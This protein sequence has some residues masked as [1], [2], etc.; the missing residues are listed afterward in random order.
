MTS[1]QLSNV[2][3][4]VVLGGLILFGCTKNS[5]NQPTATTVIPAEAAEIVAT[6]ALPAEQ[7]TAIAEEVVSESVIDT[8]QILVSD[9]ID[10]LE[11]YYLV[12][13]HPEA[14]VAVHLW[15]TLTRLN[16]QLEVEP[17]LAES[18]RLVN[19]FTWEFKLRPNLFFHNDEQ[20]TA[21]AVKF[22]ATRSK[23]LPS[24]LE[25]FMEDADIKTVE[26]VDEITVRF[27]TNQPITNLPYHLTFLEI[28]P[29]AYYQ[30]TSVSQL[31]IAPVGSGPYRL[32]QETTREQLVLE[33]A[34]DYWGGQPVISRLIFKTMPEAEDRLAE[35][36]DD[37]V[38]TIVTDLPP[39]PLAEWDISGSRLE[40]IESTQRLFVGMNIGAN[41][42]F[43]NQLVRQAL[44]YAVDVEQITT[45]LQH[46]YGQRY[47]SWVNPPH[48]DPDLKPWPYDPDQARLLLEEA[49]YSSGITTTLATPNGVYYNDVQVAE[50]IADQ[51]KLVG[52]NVVVEE[53]EWPIYVRRLLD[54]NPPSLFLLGLNSHGDPI[55]DAKN[56][57]THFPFNPTGWKNDKFELTLNR[58]TYAFE[59]TVR[60]RRLYEAQKIAYNESPWIWLWRPYRFYGISDGLSWSPRADGWVYLYK[61]ITDNQ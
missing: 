53:M 39:G 10:T 11:P 20:I 36:A 25:T 60:A 49:G 14:S 13:A 17:A 5:P 34:S 44:N 55:E 45:D 28:L 27:I 8:V 30:E 21:E 15:D 24:S 54:K 18:W 4:W 22:S 3:L 32:S 40:A 56:L 57:S 38:L 59:N 41:T 43:Q 33:A 48:N 23:A 7:E 6:E 42:P 46:G 58:V 26:V 2:I 1:N 35:L 12:N 50:A 47:G 9:P 52:V 29:P 51:L 61:P 19:N 31:A 16:G 37:D